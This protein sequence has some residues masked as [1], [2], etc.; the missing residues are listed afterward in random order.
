MS[1]RMILA[2]LAGARPEILRQAPGDIAKYA[3]LGG[4]LVSTAAV[5]GVSAFFALRTA[6]A[7]PIAA[8]VAI[9][10][11]WAVIIINLDRMLIVSMNGLRTTRLKLAAALP[12]LALALVIGTVISTPLVLRVFQPEIHAQLL[13]MQAQ[14]IQS[15]EAGLDKAYARISQL[16]RQETQLENVISGRTVPA[17]ADDPDVVAATKAYQ[18]A[19]TTYQHLEQQTLCEE[20]GTCGTHQAGRGSSFDQKNAAAQQ[21]LQARNEAQQHLDQVTA[22]VTRRDQVS[23]KTQATQARQQL[24]TVQRDLAT[25]QARRRASEGEDIQAQHE[26]TG[27]IARLEALQ[28]VTA[29]HPAAWWAHTMLFLLF[30]LIELLP[31]ITKLLSSMG[32]QSLYERLAE[33]ADSEADKADLDR[34]QVEHDLADQTA[35]ARA[36]IAQTQLDAQLRVGQDAAQ[37]L[38]DEQ[39]AITMK[40]ISVWAEMAKLRSDEELQRWYDHNVAPL[41]QRTQ[42]IRPVPPPGPNQQGGWSSPAA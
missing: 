33:R 21:A 31:V 42:P 12:R 15:A 3:T 40:A 8:C 6:L 5:A 18:Q 32:S 19:D 1:V 37:R 7:L 29:G 24:P 17:V 30:V 9:G 20:D 28:Q 13:V 14:G 2:R 25:A 16:Q 35:Q 23:S 27:L 38:A 41:S 10:L 36:A 39:A 4:V 34:V 22:T 11:G 26:D